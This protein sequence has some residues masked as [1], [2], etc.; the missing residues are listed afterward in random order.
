MDLDLKFD[1]LAILDIIK[2]IYCPDHHFEA[3]M[4]IKIEKKADWDK[5][6]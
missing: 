5:G 6:T 3:H 4:N 1:P 2:R